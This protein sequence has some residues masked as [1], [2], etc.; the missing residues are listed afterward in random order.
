MNTSFPILHKLIKNLESR[1]LSG[2]NFKSID[3]AREFAK[4]NKLKLDPLPDTASLLGV[5]KVFYT[6]FKDTHLLLVID[7]DNAHV[8]LLPDVAHTIYNA[9]RITSNREWQ[10]WAMGANLCMMLNSL[11]KLGANEFRFDRDFIIGIQ[12]VETIY[13]LNS[14]DY[15]YKTL[16]K[17]LPKIPPRKPIP[18]PDVNE[19]NEEHKPKKKVKD[20][21]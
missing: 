3:I 8:E 6:T 7:K 11:K 19:E 13:C 1:E 17:Y 15:P 18:I 4:K 20:K 5:E 21:K 2:G 12:D 14:T 9:Y 16:D 10:W